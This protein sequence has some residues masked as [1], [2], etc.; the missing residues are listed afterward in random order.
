MVEYYSA[1]KRNKLSSH[2]KR[3]RKL[4]CIF[5]KWNKPI[6]KGY[7]WYDSNYITFCKRLIY[8]DSQDTG[9]C[10]W[11]Q[12]KEGWTGGALRIFRAVK[13]FCKTLQWCINV[14][15]HLPQPRD[16][17]NSKNEPRKA[18]LPNPWAR[19]GASPRPVRDGATP[20]G[21][22]RTSEPVKP[23]L[24]LPIVH[25]TTWTISP[26]TQSLKKMSS[27]KPV[28]GAKKVGDHCCKVWTWRDAD[29]SLWFTDH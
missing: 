24:L 15:I 19:T 18:G 22:W 2:E 4:K 20:E 10:Q 23:H 26:H 13:L 3:R 12:E 6:W 16:Y 11:L 1:L 17:P 29:V 8:G 9:H 27:M 14:I 21:E 28:L 5:T 7:I 25:T